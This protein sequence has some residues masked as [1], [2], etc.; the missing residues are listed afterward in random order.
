MAQ[1]PLAYVDPCSKC[2]QFGS[3]S[4]S[5]ALLKLDVLEKELKELKKVLQQLVDKK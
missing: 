5:Q 2:A 1:C 4:P 3:C